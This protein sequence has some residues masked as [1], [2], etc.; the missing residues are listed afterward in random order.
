VNG[1]TS[2]FAY[3]N[4]QRLSQVLNQQGSTTLDQHTYTLDYVGNRTQLAEV[5]AQGGSG[6]VSPTTTYVCEMAF[7][8]V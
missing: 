4:A 2:A 1:T 6:S 5:L 7:E 8:L 3:D